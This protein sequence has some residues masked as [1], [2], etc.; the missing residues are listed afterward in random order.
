M[1]RSVTRKSRTTRGRSAKARAELA[2]SRPELLVD[3]SDRLFNAM[4]TDLF[5]LRSILNT[6]REKRAEAAGLGGIEYGALLTLARL[7][8]GE[9]G[10]QELADR[11]RL[12]GAFTTSTVN[13]LVDKG[14]VG[15]APHP[16]D[17]RRVLLSVTD[18][19]AALLT[20]F[21]PMRRQ[22]NDVAFEP[23]TATQFHQFAD[24]IDR[25]KASTERALAL[26][27]YLLKAEDGRGG[28]P[29]GD[30]RRTA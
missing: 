2:V 7:P 26:Q 17:K 19:G 25:L 12:S 14:L 27:D 23:L 30:R 13:V 3:G 15:K 29:G 28:R 4:I 24:L 18:R 11:L 21:G 20:R 8:R 16:G 5:S 6:M 1:A 10:V 9:I 22:V